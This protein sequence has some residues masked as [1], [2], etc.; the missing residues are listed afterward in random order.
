MKRMIATTLV[1]ALLAPA[2]PAF[3]ADTTPESTDTA[4]AVRQGTRQAV[5]L[6]ESAKQATTTEAAAYGPRAL[7]RQGSDGVRNQMGGGGGGKTGM[8]IGLVSAAAGIGLTI[9]MV[10][11]MKKTTDAASA[12]K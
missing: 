2:L 11:Y 8:I 3:A 1:V 9:Y 6:R 4:Y 7:P 10:K 5:S 12:A